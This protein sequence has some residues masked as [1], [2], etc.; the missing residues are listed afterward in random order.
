MKAL[1]VGGGG[2]VLGVIAL[3]ADIKDAQGNAY[4]AVERIHFEN[5]HFRKDIG[6]RAL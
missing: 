3:G 2:R 4:A 6:W 5:A 1:V